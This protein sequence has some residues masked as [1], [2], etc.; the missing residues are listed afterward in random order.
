MR[1]G[2]FGLQL[3]YL[4]EALGAAGL[5]RTLTRPGPLH[6]TT[7]FAPSNAAFRAMLVRIC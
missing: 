6:K 3:A 5:Y 7:L 2:R 4:K 1:V